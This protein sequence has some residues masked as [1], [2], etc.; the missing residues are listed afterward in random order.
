MTRDRKAIITSGLE[1]SSEK[2]HL[3]AREMVATRCYNIMY[4]L[5]KRAFSLLER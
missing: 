5:D 2:Q 4:I 3:I 1:F